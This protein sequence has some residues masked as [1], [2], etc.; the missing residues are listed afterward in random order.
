M[1]ARDFE[2]VP[3]R[4]RPAR[5]ARPHP[6]T[7]GAALP[8]AE[9]PRPA[10]NQD[11]LHQLGIRARLTVSEPGD[12]DEREA[13]H[14]A[15]AFVTSRPLARP[16]SGCAPDSPTLSRKADDSPAPP[17]VTTRAVAGV[18]G[19]RGEVMA[20]AVRRPFERFFAT[21]LGHVRVHDN[22]AAAHAARALGARAF[23]RG[24]DIYFG[25]GRFAPASEEG[26]HL[27]AHELAH[28]LQSGPDRVRR[29]TEHC[30]EALPES[31]PAPTCRPSP[32]VADGGVTK[33]VVEAVGRGDVHAVTGRLDT[34][35]IPELKAIRTAVHDENKV[36][37]ERWLIAP[38]RAAA[39]KSAAA[40]ALPLLGPLVPGA[41]LAAPLLAGSLRTSGRA[42]AATANKGL[43][44]LWPAI[45]LLERLALYDEGYRVVEQAQIEVICSTPMAERREALCDVARL[46]AVYKKMEASE[47]YEARLLI[48]PEDRYEAVDQFVLRAQGIVSDDEDPL[49]TAL[50]QLSPADRKRLWKAREQK[51]RA[52]VMDDFFADLRL[53]RLQE[54]VQGGE[55]Q[56]LIARLQLATERRKDDPAGVQAV[57]DRVVALFRERRT[58]QLKLKSPGLSADERKKAEARI[59][60]LKELDKL[61]DFQ[62]SETGVLPP[63]TFMAML[64]E[65][66]GAEGFGADVAR[67]GEFVEAKDAEKFAIDAARQ[68]I[69]LSAG[70]ADAIALIIKTLHAPPVD[71]APGT[72]AREREHRQHL[73][74]IA[75]RQKVLDNGPVQG[76]I[77]GL[78]G[79]EQRRVK[80]AI[81]ADRYDEV[82]AQAH[83]A[84]NAARWG[85]FFQVVFKIAQ[86]P[87]WKKKFEEEATQHVGAASVFARADAAGEPGKV[88]RE[89]LADPRRLP[90]A[91]ILAYSGN[92][93]L[94]RDAFADIGEEQRA[95]L[96]LGYFLTKQPP[97][98]AL[99]KAQDDALQAYRKLESEVRASQTTAGI[100]SRS[101]F[102]A[103]LIAVLGS[104]PTAAELASDEGRYQAAAIM[105]EQ[106]LARLA[107]GR[108]VVQHFTE[109]DETMDAAAREFEALWLRVRDRKKLSMIDYST[110][111]ALHQR[112][113]SR[114]Q[115]F[116]DTGN[117]IGEMA[118]MVAATVAGIVVVAATGGA[119]TP[120]VI[121]LAAAAGAGS[122]VVTRE[123]FGGE[124]YKALSDEGARDALLG[125]VDA[126][127]AVVGGQLAS[128][129]TE[130]LGFGGRALT[131][132]AA[133]LA[134]EVTEQATQ[135]FARKVAASAVEGALDG[136]FS[137]SISE[138]FGA[139]TDAR[140]WRRGIANGLAQVGQAAL[141]GGLA[142]L[143]GGAVAGAA[144]ATL[145]HGTSWLRN[146]VAMQGLES[147]LRQAGV[148]PTLKAA[149]EAALRGDLKAM[150][151]LVDKLE[152]H[153]TQ[154]QAR[155]L[156]EQLYADFRSAARH[157]PGTVVGKER[158][159]VLAKTAG[160]SDGKTLTAAERQAEIDVVAASQPQPSTVAGYVDEVDLGNQHV[161][162]RRPDGTWCRFSVKT[163]CGTTIPGAKPPSP[164]QLQKLQKLESAQ[165]RVAEAQEKVGFI[166]Q[167]Y[168]LL[169]KLET[170]QPPM[171]VG[172]LSPSERETLAA[173]FGERDPAS[174]TL[175]DVQAARADRARELAKTTQIE[176]PNLLKAAEKAR[177]ETA[178]GVYKQLRARS[179]GDVRDQIIARARN[180]E[181]KTIDEISHAPLATSNMWVD[182]VVPLR[183]MIDMDGFLLLLPDEQLKL[184]NELTNLKAMK[185]AANQ[186]RNARPFAA[187]PQG[188]EHYTK[189]QLAAMAQAEAKLRETLQA[190]I[191]EM[192]A[193]R[194]VSR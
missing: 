54:L 157:P 43:S 140:T 124:Y 151:E 166:R 42:A 120:A 153:L 78:K 21:D 24:A 40:T 147:T 152:A 16:C 23:T 60:E 39:W 136:A 10:G 76:V 72:E 176:I 106:Q 83:A 89:I 96:R 18:A 70:D 52:L 13:D 193:R 107:L 55:V 191:N 86:N 74:N 114:T 155:V 41:G 175:A 87:A 59:E 119:A 61:L 142:G 188:L 177:R 6:G 50:L 62:R 117:M 168:D 71:L 56:A 82:Y 75:F 7:H 25:V 112:F 51:L 184:A 91:K 90:L 67:F 104:E 164:E 178:E 14:Q 11:V 37:L 57:V 187:W 95:Q 79:S 167:E 81:A 173:V 47:E 98:G 171:R 65:A 66:R 12:A 128:R 141:V 29:Q 182:H 44:L 181:G 5:T 94:I 158:E 49:F 148:E 189:E 110:L 3:A 35:T 113:E 163:L 102:T 103:V 159:A 127:L 186:S 145:G 64:A 46:D 99:T 125:A 126:A 73:A 30:K 84:L 9:T 97:A 165:A 32:G 190:R 160:K 121:A 22:H 101:G 38:V 77:A 129:G 146:A 130:L 149:R 105:Y 19:S 93:E 17:P 118:G 26:R 4:R 156:R 161:W 170:Q 69:L 63:N 132:N 108:G 179:P 48:K 88:M 28:T 143:G 172:A 134:G 20:P 109:T 15:D 100:F 174:L 1:K 85:E 183:E 192:L 116:V 58:L 185:A 111:V 45:P 33:P 27:L 162:R 133:R 131:S 154:D 135:K 31:P 180:A 122:R 138:A 68:R 123:M 115:E 36:L 169:R 8:A 34:R 53:Q 2:P 80:D 150:N 144:L 137:G 194:G 139:M 92:V